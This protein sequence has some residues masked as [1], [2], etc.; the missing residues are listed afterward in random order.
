MNFFSFPFTSSLALILSA[1][2]NLSIM[3]PTLI[4]LAKLD[5]DDEVALEADFL[6]DSLTKYSSTGALLL[7]ADATLRGSSLDHDLLGLDPLGDDRLGG[8][9]DRG[10]PDNDLLGGLLDR[11]L[12]EDGLLVELLGRHPPGSDLLEEPLGITCLDSYLLIELL[13][14]NLPGNDLL[15]K[16]LGSRSPG[17][18]LLGE[19]SGADL[20]GSDLLDELLGCRPL[21]PDLLVELLGAD[22]LDDP[23]PGELLGD[24]S[25]D[26]LLGYT[27]LSRPLPYDLLGDPSGEAANPGITLLDELL[28][29]EPP[30]RE[31]LGGL[32]GDDE[33]PSLESDSCLSTADLGEDLD[34]LA[35]PP[36]ALLDEVLPSSLTLGAGGDRGVEARARA[37]SSGSGA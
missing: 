18:D 34:L 19:F 27:F 2:S 5:D 36:G 29:M 20:L 24:D 16:P 22:L 17:N 21:D 4:L 37:T 26:E 9:L 33:V 7:L 35:E 1:F 11:D 31:L 30:E 12:L 3:F 6:A 25:L 14:G 10:L 15:D 32:L 8:L 28:Y 23:P 13:G